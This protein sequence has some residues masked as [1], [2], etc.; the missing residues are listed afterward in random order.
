MAHISCFYMF[1]QQNIMLET[2][3]LVSPVETL[4]IAGALKLTAALISTSATGS[5][6]HSRER[7]ITHHRW[8][9][10]KNRGNLF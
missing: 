6:A 3:K 2:R 1:L 5:G 9:R 8:E 4:K 10:D 7:Q